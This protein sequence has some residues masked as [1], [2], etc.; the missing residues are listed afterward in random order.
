M[1]QDSS[2]ALMRALFIELTFWSISVVLWMLVLV[3]LGSFLRISS[4]FPQSVFLTS[5]ICLGSFLCPVVMSNMMYLWSEL[6]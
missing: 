4:N 3:R 5:R 6:E 1:G 2:N